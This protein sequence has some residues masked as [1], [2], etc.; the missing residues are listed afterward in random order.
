MNKKDQK[1]SPTAL[2]LFSGCGGLTLGLRQ[3]GF[4]VLGAVELD[5]KACATYR[6]N[7]VSTLLFEKDIKEVCGV[8]IMSELGLELGELDLLAGCPPCQGFSSLKTKN[9]KASVSDTRNDLI[10]D[11][12]RLVFE[13]N[14]KLVMLEN[15]PNLQKD[16]RFK[17]FCKNLKE[18]GYEF[19]FSVQN[20]AD[21]GVPQRRKRLILLASR[22]GFVTLAEPN[23]KRVNVYDVIGRLVKP[24]KSGDP[25]HDMKRNHS[26]KVLAIMSAIPR[27]GGSRSSLPDNLV[28][29]CHKRHLGY[30]DVYG[31]MRWDDVAPTITSGCINPSK[32]RFTH[33][34][35]N[36]VI[37]LRE[38]ALLQ[39][40][41]ENYRFLPEYGLNA[42]ALMIGNALPPPFIEKHARKL[43]SMLG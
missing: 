40:F 6:T 24:G 41:P 14:P 7:H 28:L 22:I 29:D 35:Q 26:E 13:L 15:V 8:Q 3:A 21:Y 2:D 19:T 12:L 38:A 10:Y 16:L 34:T 32:G 23:N 20:V 27:N 43:L 42:N 36:R 18:F 5:K 4:S 17:K 9:I 30:R 1:K 31:R 25:I 39:G 33:P 37:T 11:F